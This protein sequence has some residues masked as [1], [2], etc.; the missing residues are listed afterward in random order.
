MLLPR[1]KQVYESRVTERRDPGAEEGDVEKTQEP[2]TKV[3]N[4]ETDRA[5][6][7]NQEMVDMKTRK[8]EKL[9]ITFLDVL[10]WS[11]LGL[12]ELGLLLAILFSQFWSVFFSQCSLGDNLEGNLT[13]TIANDLDLQ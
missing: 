3:T 7:N 12:A 11:W 4:A 1:L 2:C 5:T 9:L 10:F 8:A 13:T 6:T